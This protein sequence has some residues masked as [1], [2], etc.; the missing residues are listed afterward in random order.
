[1]VQGVGLKFYVMLQRREWGIEY[2]KRRRS[3]IRG[4]F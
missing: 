4:G 3:K 1:M 2:G